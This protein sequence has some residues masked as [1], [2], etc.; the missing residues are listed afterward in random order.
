MPQI[1]S[2]TDQLNSC[3][4]VRQETGESEAPLVKF[5][6]LLGVALAII[7]LV[8]RLA[9]VKAGASLLVILGITLIVVGLAIVNWN[10]K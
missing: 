5:R 7:G 9:A 8:I 2:Q 10:G 6:E 3:G 1:L 4:C